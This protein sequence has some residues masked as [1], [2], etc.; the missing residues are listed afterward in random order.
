MKSSVVSES[1]CEDIY[2]RGSIALNKEALKTGEANQ[3]E[4][5]QEEV[6]IVATGPISE[7]WNQ[8]TIPPELN[9]MSRKIARIAMG[10]EHAVFLFSG[11]EIAVWGMNSRGQLG[12]P[13]KDSDKENRYVDLN[14]VKYELFQNNRFNVIDIAAGTYHTMFL[15]EPNDP[16]PTIE[17]EQRQVYVWGDRNMLGKFKSK[18]CGEPQL[19]HIERFEDNPKLKIKFIYA[20]NEKWIVMDS[21]NGLTLWGRDFDGF[22]QRDPILFWEFKHA[23]K[24]LAVGT[25]HGL[26]VDEHKKLYAWGDGTYGEIGDDKENELISS[27]TPTKIAFFW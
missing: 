4:Y 26:A 25:R 16:D 21:E 7:Y 11:M 23:I 8:S 6:R 19:V 17:T 9:Y 12:L 15:V 13:I 3:G 20:S 27:E 2:H 5:E 14:I 18:N 24:K 22:L 10:A 1:N